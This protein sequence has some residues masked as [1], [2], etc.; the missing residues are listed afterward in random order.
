[1]QGTWVQSLVWEDTTCCGATKPVCRNCQPQLLKLICLEPVLQNRRSHSNEK[2]THHRKSGP[3][4][5]QLKLHV[6]M[7]TQHSQKETNG[8]LTAVRRKC[9][10]LDMSYVILPEVMLPSPPSFFI[11]WHNSLPILM[12][13]CSPQF[14]KHT[15]FF[16]CPGSVHIS[17]FVCLACFCSCS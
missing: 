1:M 2:A 10:L 16:L 3:Y 14:F 6:T 5:L 15:K 13:H 7:K 12:P 8:H 4:S 17:V 11:P 9:K